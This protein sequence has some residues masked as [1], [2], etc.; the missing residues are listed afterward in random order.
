MNGKCSTLKRDLE[1]QENYSEKYRVENMKLLEENELI[2]QQMDLNQ[3][4]QS[5]MKK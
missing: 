3:K 5:L 2:K 1:Y 4:D